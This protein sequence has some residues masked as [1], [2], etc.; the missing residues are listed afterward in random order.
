M[1][2]LFAVQSPVHS[3]LRFIISGL[4]GLSGLAAGQTQADRVLRLRSPE[5]H[6][7]A[8]SWT[9]CQSKQANAD[10]AAISSTEFSPGSRW[11]KAIVPGT[12]LNSLVANGVY[13]EPYFGLNNAHEESVIPDISEVGREF[14]TYWF[15]TQFTTPAEFRDRAE[16][17]MEFEGVNQKAEIWL[18][19]NRVGELAGMFQR[20]LFP[21]KKH[22]RFDGPNALAVLVHPVEHPG[23][24]QQKDKQVRAA[25]E[26]R[27]GGDGEIGRNTTMLMTVG[28]DFTF[29]DGIRDRNTGIWKDVK[30]FASGPVLLRHPY[31]RSELPIPAL[32][33]ARETVS[34]ELTNATEEAQS[35]RL[36]GSIRE[37]DTAFEKSVSLEPGEKKTVTFTPGE[38]EQLVIDNPRLWWPFNKGEQA[39]YHLDLE[40]VQEGKVSDRVGTRFGI[41]DVRS[42]RE[43]PDTSRQFF[44]N[45]RRFFLHGSNWIPE[46]MCRNSRERTEAELRYTRQSGVSF[47][48]F[49]AGGITESDEFFDLCD[50]LGI[51]VWTEFWQSGDTK[52]PDD[53]ELYRE[54]VADTIKRIRNHPSQCYYVSANER[55]G[56]GIV[57]IKDL[58]DELH[59]NCG[60]QTGSEVDGV[61]DG[62]PY[63]SENAMF[64]Y[65]DTASKRGSRINGLC[66]EYGT[67]TMPTVDA[68]R[69]MM[70]E[71]DLWPVDKK[72]WDY[73]DG[74]GFHRMTSNFDRG[75][76]HYGPSKNIEEYAMKGQAFGGLCYR[77]IWECWNANK[78][79]YGDRF[80]TGLLFW[81][82]NSPNRQVCGRMWDWSLEPTSALY[83]SQD[84]HEPLHAQMDFLK[85]TVGVNNEYLRDFS[86]KL[87]V[88]IIDYNMKEV[89][90]RSVPVKVEAEAFRPDVADV[91]IP[92]DIT[93]VHFIKLELQ[94]SKGRTFADTFYWRSDKP[95][96][97]PRTWTGPLLEGFEPLGEL[98]V[99]KPVSSVAWTREGNRSTATVRVRN[100]GQNL[101]FLNWLRLQHADD[102]KPVRP[103]FYDDNFFT[104]LP[105][106]ERTVAI[107]YTDPSP[108][109]MKVKL[110]VDGWNIDPVTHTRSVADS[111]LPES[112]TDWPEGAEPKVVGERVARKFIESAHDQ[113]GQSDTPDGIPFPEASAWLGGLHFA[114]SVG[115]PALTQ[116]LADRFEPFFGSGSNRV[117]EPSQADRAVFGAV[118]LELYRRTGEWKYLDLGQRYADQQWRQPS[119]EETAGLTEEAKAAADR[120]LSPQT[121]GMTED[122]FLITALQTSA[123]LA[124]GE[125]RYLD[126]AAEEMAYLL[127]QLQQDNGLFHHAPDAPVFWGRGNGWAAVGM[128]TLLEAMPED[129]PRREVILSAYRQMMAG[130]LETQGPEGAWNQLVDDPESGPESSC[131]GMFTFALITGVREG[132]L[133]A[134]LYGPAARKGW[135]RL[136]RWIDDQ[137]DLQEVSEGT[138][139]SSDREVYLQLKRRAGDPHGQAAV[140]WCAGALSR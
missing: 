9:M 125:H 57:P 94:N 110:V 54:N 73:L 98:P 70:S 19:G 76:N 97:R 28:W 131:T 107:S 44:V 8:H 129:H 30:L 32:S 11:E 36:R 135:L 52:I 41:R 71:D 69:E 62:S 106:E 35:G 139:K 117:P 90:R 75:I 53:T 33:P 134:G 50:E 121:R 95:Y 77:A 49:W 1:P 61:H 39:L 123:W 65:E 133:D 87:V 114:A 38:F 47:L 122:L 74:G 3:I 78:F 46:A 59:D 6:G 72:V 100:D 48:R 14:Y 140:L 67:P 66:P 13:P 45:G 137:G 126:Q 7:G 20:G 119:P 104:L 60:Y 2:R 17:W 64:H 12:V 55:D 91:P 27:N 43:T 63:L 23:G 18:N 51:L 84:A 29:T 5:F 96:R 132:W 42:N 4:I 88:R 86:G 56:N 127:E 99:V 31:V 108:E 138:G 130:L 58:I 124:T 116:K 80:S 68:L 105:G 24:F 22:L 102:S 103:A 34:V 128:S 21:V 40:F 136:T 111:A 10:G 89:Y 109:P 26:N 120:G 37:T 93:P 81:Y 85:N 115:D 101:A 112:L 16:V 15:R 113:S 25:G 82:H 118:P 79:D 83:F 92:K